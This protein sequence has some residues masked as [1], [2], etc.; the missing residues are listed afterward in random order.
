MSST[1]T[2]IA[3]TRHGKPHPLL[4]MGGLPGP[5]GVRLYKGKRLETLGMTRICQKLCLRK[6]RRTGC[7]V[8]FRHPSHTHTPGI[9][10]EQLCLQIYAHWC[11]SR[12]ILT[13][14][15]FNSSQTASVKAGAGVEPPERCKCEFTAGAVE[16]TGSQGGG[17]CSFQ[18]N[19]CQ[20]GAGSLRPAAGGRPAFRKG[21]R[22]KRPTERHEGS[23]SPLLLEHNPEFGC[24]PTWPASASLSLIGTKAEG[25]QNEFCLWGQL[26]SVF[27]IMNKLR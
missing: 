8:L 16:T 11:S 19:G 4:A 22:G 9:L 13:S 17:A 12:S 26:V 24:S 7:G 15:C 5:D 18:G 20:P 25:F 23:W 21:R 3:E 27:K 6:V 14:S 1:S 2:W 10:P